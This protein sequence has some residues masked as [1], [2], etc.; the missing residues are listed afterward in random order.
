[1]GDSKTNFKITLFTQLFLI[2]DSLT[3]TRDEMA[4]VMYRYL[5]KLMAHISAK[6]FTKTSTHL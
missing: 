2:L 1:M 4:P 5:V 6:P 3:E